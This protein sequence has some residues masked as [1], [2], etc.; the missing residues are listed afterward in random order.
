MAA[1]N[2]NGFKGYKVGHFGV[3][4]QPTA[5]TTQSPT[6]LYIRMS[7]QNALAHQ[8]QTHVGN[9]V[10]VGIDKCEIITRSRQS[11]R[12][13]FQTPIDQTLKWHRR[14]KMIISVPN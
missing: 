10:P 14:K 12:H 9:V 13:R 5:T 2:L 4:Q 11:D 6:G 7:T 1:P 8:T 3:F